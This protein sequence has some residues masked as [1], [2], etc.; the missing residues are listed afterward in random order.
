MRIRRIKAR[1][2]RTLEDLE[3]RFSDN[4]CTLSGRNN[5]G[6]S[7]VIRLL[8]GL[9]HPAIYDPW[10][11]KE[12]VLRY[13]D[14][15]TQWVKDNNLIEVTFELLLSRSDD[16]A[17]ISFIERI[18]SKALP[19]DLIVLTA[20]YIQ[21]ETGSATRR[22]TIQNEDVDDKAAREIE[23]R[24][25]GSNLLFLYNSTSPHEAF[26]YAG[27]RRFMYYDF[28]MS[29]E[30]QKALETAA[31][32]LE[33][34]LKTL[35]KEHMHGLK[36]MLGKLTDRYDVELSPPEGYA[37]RR[38]PLGIN[39]RDRHVEVPIMDWGSGTQNRTRILMAILRAS[40]I[41]NR[42][43]A[44][45]K[46]TPIVVIEEP[47]SFLHPSAQAE[48]GRV[49]RDIA[50]E[51][52]IQI[53]A[54]THSPY[55]LNQ[56]EPA[57]NILLTRVVEKGRVGKTVTLATGDEKWMTPFADHLGISSSEF[58]RIRDI[59]A[60]GHQKVLL[61]EGQLDQAYFEFLRAHQLEC[62]KLLSDV[63]VVAYGGKD[64]L[65]NTVLVKFVLSRFERV[66]VTYDL[67]AE[68]ECS[69]AHTRAGL[70][71]DD[72]L[73]LGRNTPGRDC[74]EGLLPDQV[75]SAVNGREVDLVMKLTSQER[76]KAKEELKQKYLEEF[77]KKTD[78]SAHGHLE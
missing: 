59:F 20:T 49:L 69:S 41:K 1:N 22:M 29:K 16:P 9:L 26:Y 7:A 36:E 40:R 74:I 10:E 4:Y 32:A 12:E 30:E 15:K 2:Y 44:E 78:Y 31:K 57:S 54:T 62:E 47:E 23:K 6:K 72:H 60:S 61:V 38:M 45:E 51:V 63:E 77:S 68:G 18:S 11:L 24:L 48:F 46:I 35:A 73:A 71:D 65:K 42:G 37:T 50:G 33:R 52:G 56:E 14:D 66:F 64:T 34:S 43:S 67:D 25:Q 39:L 3:L 76:R 53:I 8:I 5:A 13:K 55:M 75:L 27:G 70:S 21:A 28:E 58:T 17:L 19:G